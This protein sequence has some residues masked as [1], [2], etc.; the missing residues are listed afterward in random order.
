MSTNSD[1]L[2]SGA[3]YKGDFRDNKRTGRGIH[4][5]P[6]GNRYEGEFVDGKRTGHGIFTW[7]S[8]S[9]YEGNFHDNERHGHGIY[10]WPNGNRYEGGFVDGDRTGH[11]TFMRPSGSR[12][13]GG[14]VDGEFHGQG[15]QTWTTGNRYKGE[16]RNN[17]RTGHGVYTWESGGRYEGEF[18]NGKLHGQ[19]VRTWTNGERYEGLWKSGLPNATATAAQIAHAR[20][21]IERLA[22]GQYRNNCDHSVT[23]HYCYTETNGTIESCPRPAV[24]AGKHENTGYYTHLHDADPAITFEIPFANIY[25]ITRAVCPGRNDGTFYLAVGRKSGKY[26]CRSMLPSI[27]RKK[28]KAHDSVV[29]AKRIERAT[30]QARLEREIEE[31][32]R[33]Q[34]EQDLRD[35]ERRQRTAQRR[36]QSRMQ[37]LNAIQRLAEMQEQEQARRNREEA[38][39]YERY[40]EE[41]RRA[42]GPQCKPDVLCSGNADTECL[43]YMEKYRGLPPC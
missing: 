25:G 34:H 14:F 10:I 41:L 20:A 39:Q 12:Y 28:S 26:I 4:T 37:S 19:G 35:T 9:R 2:H 1:Q 32:Q 7:P 43:A 30:E 22:H 13:E 11:G 40:V 24:K 16:F 23:F 3:R 17:E 42:S 27:T 31:E 21:C 15:D 18:L 38:A 6:N 29:R 5:S 33:W 8:G 36:I